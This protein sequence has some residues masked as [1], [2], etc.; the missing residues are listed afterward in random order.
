[1][2]LA[3]LVGQAP[4]DEDVVGAGGKKLRRVEAAGAFQHARDIRL[5]QQALDQFGLGL[6]AGEGDL[7]ERT[8][9]PSS[10]A[11]ATFV[12]AALRGTSAAAAGAALRFARGSM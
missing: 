12:A 3:G 9:A 2:K 7:D 8:V 11:A 10:P 5:P 1:E 4:A 6:I